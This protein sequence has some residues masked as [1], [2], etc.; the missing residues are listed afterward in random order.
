MVIDFFVK[1][2]VMSI[3]EEKKKNII[4]VIK[5]AL[6]STSAGIIQTLLFTLLNEKTTLPYA[7]TYGTALAASV[8]WN[9][10]FNRKFTFK[11]A[12]NVP[13][14]ML[15]AFTF[16]IFFAP[17]SIW[18]GD[19]LEGADWNE[20]LVLAITMLLNLSLEF[21]WQKFVVFRESN[22]KKE[23]DS[24]PSDNI[25]QSDVMQNENDTQDCEVNEET[26]NKDK[27]V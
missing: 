2:Y 6:F 24:E 8:L 10:T 3:N 22:T 1:E 7:L 21:L 25:I 18:G 4:Q 23:Q 9:F 20:Y 16:Y 13:K 26:Q 19:A 17:L 27:T 12:S 15:L 5:F 11:S 14:A